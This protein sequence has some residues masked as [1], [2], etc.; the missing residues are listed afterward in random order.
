MKPAAA[1]CNCVEQEISSKEM[2]I[3]S[4]FRDIPDILKGIEIRDL[5]R[6]QLAMSA[7]SDACH[8]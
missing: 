3:D 2:L 7:I 1:L 8:H 4:K 5:L 6:R